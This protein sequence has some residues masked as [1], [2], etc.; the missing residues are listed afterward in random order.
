MLKALD[1]AYFRVKDAWQVLLG[2]DAILKAYSD[3]VIDGIDIANARIKA[4]LDTSDPHQF[5]NQHFKLGYYYA[6]ETAK[7]V[8]NH[9]ENNSVD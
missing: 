3:G 5:T 8:M 2:K 4:E 9:D 6:A 7:K 1:T